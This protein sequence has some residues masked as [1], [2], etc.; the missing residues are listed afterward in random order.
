[1]S[2]ILKALEVGAEGAQGHPH[3]LEQQVQVGR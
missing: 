2:R 1:L 3:D